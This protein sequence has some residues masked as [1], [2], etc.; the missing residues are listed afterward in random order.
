MA[1]LS[2]HEVVG[3]LVGGVD[4]GHVEVGLR[5]QQDGK[6]KKKKEV[7]LRKPGQV[8]QALQSSMDGRQ[9]ST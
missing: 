3:F 1:L 8:V 5:T 2:F 6:E 9:R 4:P 7:L